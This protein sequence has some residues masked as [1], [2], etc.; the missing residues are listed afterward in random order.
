MI[1]FFHARK[2][3]Q[4]LLYNN[5]N[6]TSVI[7][8][9][10]VCS[11]WPIGRTQSGVTTP[12]RSGPGSN[13]NEGVLHIHQISKDRVS[14]SDSL[15]LSRRLFVFVLLLLCRDAVSVFSSPADGASI[16]PVNENTNEEQQ[17]SIDKKFY[18]KKCT[19]IQFKKK[20]VIKKQL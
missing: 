16:H 18:L 2:W 4:V 17:F 7:C 15:M 8:L 12:D 20:K 6:L 5:H 9:Y 10:T 14:P 11:I 1:S 3:F 19:H 13:G